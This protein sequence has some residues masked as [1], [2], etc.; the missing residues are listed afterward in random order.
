MCR[1]EVLVDS[2]IDQL[3]CAEA[4][5]CSLVAPYSDL[6]TQML[7]NLLHNIFVLDNQFQ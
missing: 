4:I 7:I 3:I 6:R 5:D 2:R 1:D